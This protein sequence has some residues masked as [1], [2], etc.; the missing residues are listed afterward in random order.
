MKITGTSVLTW[1]FKGYIGLVAAM[2]SHDVTVKS[3][4]T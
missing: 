4:K 1:A 2:Y 3:L